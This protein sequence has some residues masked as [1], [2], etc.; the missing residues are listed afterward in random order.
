MCACENDGGEEGGRRRG[1]QMCAVE[2]VH[3]GRMRGGKGS[4]GEDKCL[5]EGGCMCGG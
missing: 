5:W 3:A 4:E 1:G 2:R